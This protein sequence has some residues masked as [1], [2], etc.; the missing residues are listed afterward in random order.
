MC[1]RHEL[2]NIGE[3]EILCDQK[4]S[5]T[6]GPIPDN[7]IRLAVDPLVFNRIGFMAERGKDPYQRGGQIL[8]QFDFHAATG[9]GGNGRSSSAEEAA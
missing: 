9:T 6:L 7:L 2:P 5:V 3:I 8:V 4:A 1:S